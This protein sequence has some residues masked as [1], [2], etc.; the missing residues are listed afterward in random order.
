ML[1]AIIQKYYLFLN[2]ANLNFDH[3]NAFSMLTQ[4]SGSLMS[5]LHNCARMRCIFEDYYFVKVRA[6]MKIIEI[7]PGPMLHCVAGMKN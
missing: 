3:V 4:K 7:T 1:I 2:L 5:N 6:I